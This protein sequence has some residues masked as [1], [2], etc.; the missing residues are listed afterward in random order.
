MIINK[1]VHVYDDT[2]FGSMLFTRR[3]S[4]ARTVPMQETKQ[5]GDVELRGFGA[6]FSTYSTAYFTAA[7]AIGM[8]EKEIESFEVQLDKT[9]RDFVKLWFLYKTEF[10]VFY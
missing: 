4:G 10:F 1:I 5:I 8:R 9:F 6:S 2:K 3:V 7:A